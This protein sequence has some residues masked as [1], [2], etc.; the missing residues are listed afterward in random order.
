MSNN[1]LF[2]LLGESAAGKDFISIKLLEKLRKNNVPVKKLISHTTRPK[3]RGEKDGVEYL[4]TNNM[5]YVDRFREG[6]ILESAIYNAF[7]NDISVKWV[8]FTDKRDLQLENSS[9]LKIIN[10][11]GYKQI[12]DNLNEDQ[13]VSIYITCDPKTRLLRAINRNGEDQ[14]VEI[15][16]RFVADYE[17]FKDFKADYIV[18]NGDNCIIDEVVDRIYGIILEELKGDR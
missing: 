14:I 15:C 4:F 12:C 8:Y 11:I 17:D 9:Y 1:K 2:C 3:R 7:D 13:V 10:P 18:Y 16:R 5:D 6:N